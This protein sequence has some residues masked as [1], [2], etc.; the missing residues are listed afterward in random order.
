MRTVFQ[1]SDVSVHR[2]PQTCL[3]IFIDKTF[4]LGNQAFRGKFRLKKST[5]ITLMTRSIFVTL[6]IMGIQTLTI[7]NNKQQLNLRVLHTMDWTL[8]QTL[9]VNHEC[10]L[11]TITRWVWRPGYSIFLK[12]GSLLPTSKPGLTGDWNM[13]LKEQRAGKGD[14]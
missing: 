6:R 10:Q 11:Q 2:A 8:I 4:M 9:T 12:P 14:A 1:R 13:K 3:F 5:V 7:R